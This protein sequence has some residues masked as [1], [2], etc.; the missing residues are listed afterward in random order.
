[1]IAN[2]ASSASLYLKKEKQAIYLFCN[3]TLSS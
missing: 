3:D 1:L 2:I